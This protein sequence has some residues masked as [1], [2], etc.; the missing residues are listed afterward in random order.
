[1]ASV[2]EIKKRSSHNPRPT[3]TASVQGQRSM[4]VLLIYALL[5]LLTVVHKPASLQT[6]DAVVLSLNFIAGFIILQ[7]IFQTSR[8]SLI[9]L[10]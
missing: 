8:H 7:I 10:D 6:Q 2:K 5:N 4:S 9:S 3:K 1:M